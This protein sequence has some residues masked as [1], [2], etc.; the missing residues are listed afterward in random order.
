M[1]Q[2]ASRRVP[3]TVGNTARAL[4]LEE[5]H[6]PAGAAKSPRTPL[7]LVVSAPRRSRKPVVVSLF[8]LV[9]GALTAVLVMSVSVSQ[10]QYQLV[11]LKNQQVALEKSNQ[12]LDLEL[13]AKEA[14][15]AL[16]AQA[17]AMGMVP[18]AAPGQ[19]DVRTKRVTGNPQPASA[20]TKGLVVLPPADVNRPPAGVKST[21][22]ADQ[23]KAE[24]PVGGTPAA[25]A[26]SAVTPDLNGGTIPAPAQ[27][28]S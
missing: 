20:D 10:G 17:T 14:P 21:T 8:L 28:A 26:P 16:V 9:L 19:I 22:T 7:S 1:S 6:P 18:A 24:K 15:Q 23:P 12:A 27:R 11:D 4:S 2:A 3:T 25:A 13:S 5:L